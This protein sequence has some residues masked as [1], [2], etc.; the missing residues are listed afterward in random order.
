MYVHRMYVKLLYSK[1]TMEAKFI[2]KLPVLVVI[3]VLNPAC[4]IRQSCSIHNA[5]DRC[6]YGQKE[7]RAFYP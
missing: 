3:V 2:R 4:V 1:I 7:P 5:G 6:Q